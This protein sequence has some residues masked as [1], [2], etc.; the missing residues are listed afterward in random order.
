MTVFSYSIHS[1]I[2]EAHPD[3]CRGVVVFRNLDNTKQQPEVTQQLRDSE[4]ALRQKIVGNPAE[5]PH[6][7]AW[8]DA[9]RQFGAKPSEHRSSIE[10]LSRRVLKPD[11]LP[12]I[13]T[14]V[15]I[16]NLLSLR[17][18]LPAGVHPITTRSQNIELRKANPLDRFLAEPGKEPE[19]ISPDE[20]VLATTNRILTRRWTWR[21]AADTRTLP[22]TSFVFFDIDGLLPST[23]AEVRA[24]IADLTHLVSRYCGGECV[25]Y[26]ILDAGNPSISISLE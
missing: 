9:Y 20:I 7:A 17:Y 25:G 3:Y 16:G 4:A 13:N 23:N 12:D 26:A 1:G 21:Q 5:H 24:A 18:V 6:I 22:E 2:F 14:L 15:D 11:S 19:P 8:R 10:A